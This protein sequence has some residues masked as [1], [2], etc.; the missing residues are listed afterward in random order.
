MTGGEMTLVSQLEARFNAVSN[1]LPRDGIKTLSVPLESITNTLEFLKY[2]SVPHYEMLFDLSAIDETDR[3]DE[4]T[5]FY[6]LL[7]LS[8]NTDLRLKVSL[9][10]KDPVLP[11]ICG[12]WRSANWYERELYDMF[13]ICV[14]NHP[15]LQRILMPEYWEG[16]PLRKEHP[17]R[18]TE[19]PP[20]QLPEAR[21]RAILAS[22]RAE[23]YREPTNTHEE[24]ILNIGPTHPGTHGLLRLV[25]RLEGEE[26]RDVRPDIGFH[27]RG[28]EKMAERQTFHSY[29]PYTDR[30]DYLSGVQNELPY[31][32]AV[33]QLAGITAPERAQVIRVM[34]CELF[35]ISSH[36]VWLASYSHDLGA[37]APPFY[38]FR[39]REYLFDVVEMITGGRMHPAFFRIGGVAEDLPEG[40]REALQGFLKR[41]P[42]AIN[43]YQTLLTDNPI[44][45][46]RTRGIGT[47]STAEAIDWGIS[48][49]N[50]RACGMAW[51]LR[52]CRPYSGY[53]QYDFDVPI[54]TEGDCLARAE[55]RLEE[56]RQSIRIVEQAMQNIPCGPT[57]SD[58][59]RYAFAH[60]QATLQDIE[61]LIHHF[62]TVGQGMTFPSGE[63]LFITEAPKGMNGYFVVSNGTAHPYRLRIRTPSFPHMQ[64]LAQL[65]NGHLLADLIAILGSIDYVLAD[66]DR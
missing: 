22:Y 51:D 14:D 11:S 25:V 10:A 41:M 15:N 39:D 63:S 55:V 12:I 42:A 24:M 8:G 18:A 49:P 26:I 57:L 1:P 21:Y 32:L 44:M 58:Q 50:L 3:S 60:K 64:A 13:G 23:D 16:H 33:E 65:A 2:E 31:L 47:L 35:R 20:Y 45:R 17:N 61:T 6:Q 48:G 27:H 5:V 29:I 66:I 19:M 38:T 62:I 53:E 34:L 28:A 36:L 7:S 43:E 9:P 52:K 37:L 59:A 54:A 46:R 56:I 40:W 30:I 4:L